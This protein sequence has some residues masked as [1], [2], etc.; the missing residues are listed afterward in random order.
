MRESTR[1]DGPVRRHTRK[2]A[3]VPIGARCAMARRPG[4][5]KGMTAIRIDGATRLYAIVGDPIV[6]VK[7]PEVFSELFARAGMNAVMIPMHVRPE[8]FEESMRALMGI[9]NVD[10]L[11][12]TVPYKAQAVQFADRL[13]PTASRI[14]AL[15]ALRRE[16]DGT[17]TGDMFDGLGFVRAFRRKGG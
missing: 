3:R 5:S 10:G 11:V 2:A 6:Q 1:T 7:S 13:G 12:A 9:A 16:P 17:W 8:R 15:N 14:R 4:K